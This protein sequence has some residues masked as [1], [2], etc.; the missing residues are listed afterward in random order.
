MSVYLIK[1]VCPKAVSTA[2]RR[3]CAVQTALNP[4]HGSWTYCLRCK[5]SFLELNWFTENFMNYN[6][7]F[8]REVL[9]RGAEIYP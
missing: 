1:L 6:F 8:Q 2:V 3:Y 7:V 5:S 9:P 4:V